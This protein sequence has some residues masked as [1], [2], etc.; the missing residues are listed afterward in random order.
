MVHAGVDVPIVPGET[1]LILTDESAGMASKTSSSAR[2]TKKR[3]ATHVE[4]RATIGPA[5]S[6]LRVAGGPAENEQRA[7]RVRHARHVT[8]RGGEGR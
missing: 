5:V 3:A 1:R 8:L 2:P 7:A 4:P 6:N